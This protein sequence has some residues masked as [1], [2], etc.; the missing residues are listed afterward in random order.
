MPM[1]TTPLPVPTLKSNGVSGEVPLQAARNGS[2]EKAE[3]E[4]GEEERP[5]YTTTSY[6]SNCLSFLQSAASPQSHEPSVRQARVKLDILIVGA[7]L[8]GLAT[9]VALRRRGHEVTVFEQAPELMEV[10]L[11]L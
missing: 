9:A 8:G 1:A 2:L 10:C 7:G 6:P 3:V 5:R 11:G 4:N